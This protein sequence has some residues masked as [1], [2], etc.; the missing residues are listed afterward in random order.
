MKFVAIT[1]VPNNTNDGGTNWLRR[2]GTP[3][4]VMAI[5]IVATLSMIV[6]PLPT[7]I[8]DMALAI[9]LSSS[10]VIL[11][12]SVYINKPLEFNVFPSVLLM[13]TVFRFLLNIATT[14]SILLHG[15]SKEGGV[16]ELIL[17]FGEVVIGGNYAVGIVLFIIIMVINFIVITKGAG[18][19]AEVAARFT[20]D[21]MPGKQMA[22]DAELNAG[23][24]N[25]EEARRRR[26]NIESEADFYGS[27]DG[28]SKMVRGDS[29]AAI[30]ITV[31]NIVVGFVIGMTQRGLSAS[32]SAKHF[33]ILAIGDGLITAI[34]ALMI[35]FA[36]AVL[37][38]RASGDTDLGTSVAKQ[39]VL[40]PK[41]LL[42]SAGV[43]TV[44]ALV[45]GFPKLAFFGLA[46]G[47]FFLS[48][49]A[50]KKF[51]EQQSVKEDADKSE[52]KEKPGDSI[53]A[54]MKVD[55][56]AVE[57]GHA[58]VNLIDPEQDGEVVDR[59]QSIRKQFAGE[60]GIVVPQIQL[61]DN[62]QLAPGQYQILLKS[63]PIATGYLMPEYF[64]AMDP[65]GVE[66]PLKGEPT[67]DPVYGLQALWIPKREREEATFRGY[68]VVNGATVIATHITKV[69]KEQAPDLLTRTDVAYLVDKLKETHPKVVDE[70]IAVD[71][72]SLGD[73]AKILQNLLREEVSIR[74]TLS[75]FECIADHCRSIK[76][77]DVLSELCRKSLSR[78]ICQKLLD[79]NGD[80]KVITLDR[81]IEDILISQLNTSENG[82][83]RLSI[84]AKY[85]NEVIQKIAR[86]VESFD[87]EGTPP[88]LMIASALRL[89]LRKLVSRYLPQITFLAYDE[90]PQNIKCV[91]LELLT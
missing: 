78:S 5:A 27:L 9:S 21:A 29:I 25:A 15:G 37:V 67:Q 6:L 84:D 45:P 63:S 16:S 35:S 85:A 23:H 81:T 75:I 4:I 1:S 54:L 14:K 32:E 48:R 70:V 56:L 68:T 7:L 72:L 33:T 17:A 71:K 62:L 53:D 49:F 46:V 2:Y 73:V 30:I 58:I 66:L 83:S 76:N 51:L 57:V 10:L 55:I 91:T 20:L 42:Y 40:H 39:F 43:M 3:E 77:C 79:Q 47:L 38:T 31:V 18:R 8:L 41:A 12:V 24:I 11:L 88:C 61:R 19:I 80:L 44:L 69:I 74:D 52:T 13:T 59:I 82:S 36:S 22:I 65:G 34:P 86:G 26:K 60:L 90:I 50:D 89:P 28:A 87:M 64:L